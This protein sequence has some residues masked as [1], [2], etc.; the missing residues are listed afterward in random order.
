MTEI[1]IEALKERTKQTWSLGDYSDIERLTGQAAQPLVDACA[2]SAGQEVLDV[3][4][5]SGNVALAAAREGA[6]VVASDITAAMLERARARAL[7]EGLEIDAVEGDVEQLPFADESFDC[8]TSA[9]GLI[10]APRPALAVHEVF[11]VLRPGGT[12][13]MTAWTPTSLVP[14][15]T[16]LAARYLPRPPGLPVAS[17][18]GD[19][20]VARARLGDAAASISTE[21]RTAQ[22]EGASVGDYLASFEQKAGPQIAARRALPPERYAELSS[23]LERLVREA[24]EGDGPV[25]L[26][27]EYLLVVARKR[28]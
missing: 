8:V 27:F 17:E 4:A 7:E 9:F 23:E 16:E 26:R 5:G 19:E 2:I 25:K 15:Q 13:G 21:L 3:A 11:R 12:F 1:D 22:W 20:T 14:R 6:R 10:L 28:G 18:W 24:A